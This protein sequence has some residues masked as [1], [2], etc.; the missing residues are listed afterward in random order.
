MGLDVRTRRSFIL[1]GLEKIRAALHP[2][3]GPPRLYINP[4]C[5][6]LIA[7]MQSYRYAEGGSEIPVKD[8]VHD[9]LIDAL[10]YFFVNHIR[11]D[12]VNHRRY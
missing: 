8:N 10:R 11:S 12:T 9:H 7:A 3:H 6:R 5:K 4:R 2:A 1:D